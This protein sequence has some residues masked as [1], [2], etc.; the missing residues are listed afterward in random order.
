MRL[1]FGRRT[2]PDGGL[3]V[4]KGALSRKSPA[5]KGYWGGSLSCLGG[6]RISTADTCCFRLLIKGGIKFVVSINQPADDRAVAVNAA[7]SQE[8][9]VTPDILEMRQIAFNNEDLFFLL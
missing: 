2:E 4:G 5:G 1:P 7:I 9:P 6:E 3:S 8:R